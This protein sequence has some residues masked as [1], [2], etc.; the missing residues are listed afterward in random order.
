[1]PTGFLGFIMRR[2]WEFYK[3]YKF[4]FH[5]EKVTMLALHNTALPPYCSCD[6]RGS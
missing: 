1:M 5:E 3:Y 2:N 4:Y 6:Q